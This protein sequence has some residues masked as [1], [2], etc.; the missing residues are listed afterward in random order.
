M[1][2][3]LNSETDLMNYIKRDLGEDSHIIELTPD[4]LLD[5]VNDALQVFIEK[6]FDGSDEAYQELAFVEGTQLYNMNENVIAVLGISAV[7]LD[8]SNKVAMQEFYANAFENI[9]D[10]GSDVVLNYA[11][12]TSYLETLNTFLTKDVLYNFNSTTK[13]LRIHG[14]MTS[15][16]TVLVH[17]LVGAGF[18][19]TEAWNRIYDN[20]YIKKQA[21]ANAWLKWAKAL[22]KFE[23]DLWDGGTKIDKEAV[24]QQAKDE[25]EE[26]KEM[27]MNEYIDSFSIV[28]K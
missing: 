25:Q 3:R 24:M 8:T 15:S 28:I 4:Q 5:C 7:N 19:G 23:G 1:F 10:M 6:C 9:Y 21:Q 16:T 18:S 12:T 26:A 20:R 2:T 17:V 11:L 27:L 14:T 13:E 22:I